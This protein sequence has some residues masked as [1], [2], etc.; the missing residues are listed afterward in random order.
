MH[1]AMAEAVYFG[2]ILLSSSPS[3]ASSL[4]LSAHKTLQLDVVGLQTLNMYY[5]S[6]SI[7]S[8]LELFLDSSPSQGL[9]FNNLPNTSGQAKLLVGWSK[10]TG[11][12]L[13]VF[14]LEEGPPKSEALKVLEQHAQIYNLNAKN[15]QEL[16]RDF[17]KNIS[18]FCFQDP[19]LAEQY[20]FFKDLCQKLNFPYMIVS[21]ACS[22][23]YGGKRSLKDIDVIV[24]S[25]HDLEKLSQETGTSIIESSSSC[26]K[27]YYLNLKEIDVNSEVTVFWE[28]SEKKVSFDFNTLFQKSRKIQFLG[29]D[30]FLMSPEDLVIFKFSLGRFG[31]D[32]FSDYKDDY[33]DVRGILISQPIN[34]QYIEEMAKKIGAWERVVLGKQLLGVKY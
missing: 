4:S 17:F 7:D 32:D 9:I 25:H 13:K 31:I 23:L 27:M 16:S 33:E 15:S 2:F 14:N 22:Y 5:S 34:W 11:I 3:T 30:C 10:R 21:G 26:A 20:F 12:K 6:E 28:Q 1:F 24:P 19:G 18:Q 29:E 8:A